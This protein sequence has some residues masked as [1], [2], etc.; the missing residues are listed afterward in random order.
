[1]M[2]KSAQLG[3]WGWGYKP[4]LFHCI[5]HHKQSCGVLLRGQIHFPYFYST[6]TY[7]VAK[8][9]QEFHCDSIE[10]AEAS[11]SLT[12]HTWTPTAT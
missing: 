12:F 6:P 1:M 3:G 9:Q 10:E 11:A 4:S 7:S 8:K 5:Y 2:E